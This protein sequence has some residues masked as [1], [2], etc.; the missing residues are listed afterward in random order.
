MTW[1]VNEWVRT[2]EEEDVPLTPSN[3][4]V[5]ESI[6]LAVSACYYFWQRRSRSQSKADTGRAWKDREDVVPLNGLS[7]GSSGRGSEGV[8]S[9]G[10]YRH[11]PESRWDVRIPPSIAVALTLLA[12]IFFTYH[13]HLVSSFSFFS[14]I[15]VLIVYLAGVTY[16]A[17]LWINHTIPHIVYCHT[18]ACVGSIR[19][20]FYD[21]YPIVMAGCTHAGTC[22]ARIS[23]SEFNV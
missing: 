1:S 14:Y 4:V 9:N 6:K 17:C 15:R 13:G 20:V 18:I 21:C 7:D 8:A 23:P 19:I 16:R 2:R 22:S 11:R 5:V 10:D 3:P 12:S